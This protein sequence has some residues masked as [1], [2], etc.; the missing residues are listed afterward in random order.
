MA[1]V[2]DVRLPALYEAIGFWNA[3]LLNLGSPFRLGPLTHMPETITSDDIRPYSDGGFDDLRLLYDWRT[4]SF[5]LRERVSKVN[6]DVVVVLSTAAKNS[7]ALGYPSLRKV[8]VVIESSLAGPIAKSSRAQNVIAHEL[9]HAI[10]LEHN[11][12]E[13]ALMCG[14]IFC[15]FAGGSDG[16][17]P[18]TR[19]DKLRL[20][21]MYPPGWQEEEGPSRR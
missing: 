13:T 19:G 20:L 21:G 8:L 6:G 14:G 4:G 16:F 3:M 11:N 17:R 9:G 5:N 15:S 18:L 10:G 12:D 7:F 1:T 2:N